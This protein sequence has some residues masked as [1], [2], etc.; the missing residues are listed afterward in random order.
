MGL[1]S[2]WQQALLGNPE[3]WGGRWGRQKPEHHLEARE[4]HVTPR[5][6]TQTGTVVLEPGSTTEFCR[7]LVKKT[8]F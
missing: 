4:C 3:A 7:V 6:V 5:I 2:V 8:K 1:W